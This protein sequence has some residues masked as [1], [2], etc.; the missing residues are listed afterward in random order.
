MEQTMLISANVPMSF[1][2]RRKVLGMNWRGVIQRGLESVDT[3]KATNELIEEYKKLKE[4][5]AR[6]AQTLQRYVDEVNEKNE[7]C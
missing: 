6:T 1:N 7:V 4:K 3:F 5:Q 2:E